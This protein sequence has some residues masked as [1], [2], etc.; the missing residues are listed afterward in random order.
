MKLA[1]IGKTALTLTTGFGLKDFIKRHKMAAGLIVALVIA[2]EIRGLAVV[3][4]VVKAWW[5]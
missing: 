1:A 2:N 4:A 5:L 3:Y